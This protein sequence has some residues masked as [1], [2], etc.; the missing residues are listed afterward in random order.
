MNWRIWTPNRWTRDLSARR[1]KAPMTYSPSLETFRDARRPGQTWCRSGANCWPTRR[2]RCPPTSACAVLRRAPRPHLPAGKR[3]GRRDHRALLLPR[4]RPALRM[5]ASGPARGASGGPTARNEVTHDVDPLDVLR[6]CMARFQPVPGPR[7]APLLRRRGGLHR[8]R[9][10]RAVRAACRSARTGPRL[11]RPGASAHRHHRDLRPRAAHHE[12]GG[13]RPRRWRR[14]AAYDAAVLR[15]ST[16]AARSHVALPHPPARRARSPA[17]PAALQRDPRAVHRRRDKAKEYIRAGDIIQVVLSQRFEVEHTGDAARRL[18]RPAL[19]QS[20]AL[21]VLPGTRRPHAWSARPRR[22]TCAAKTARW[23]CAPSRAR[24]RARPTPPPTSPGRRAAGRPQ[25]A[26]RA[27]HA[28]RPGPQRHGPRLHLRHGAVPELMV[29]ER[30]SHVMHIVSDVRG[31]LAPGRDVYDLM[32]AT[33]PAGTVSG[34]PKI[35]AMEIIAELESPA[36]GPTRARS[37]TSAS[38][39]TSTVLHHHPHRAAQRAGRPMCRP[40]RASWP[41]PTPRASTRKR[42]TRPAACCRAGPGPALCLLA[43]PRAAGGVPMILVI[44]NYDSFTYNLVQYLGELGAEEGGAQRPDH[45]EARSRRCA[46]T[47][48]SS[49][50]ARARRRGG[51]LLRTHR[52]TRPRHAPCSA[53]ASATRPSA[54]CTAARSCARAG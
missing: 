30:Y 21:H 2:P 16:S 28:G 44:D 29:I 6:D 46:R 17:P 32:R 3:G 26:G 23:R 13:Q 31:R 5:R 48:S 42:R 7:P 54:R 18:P 14:D 52:R 1:T 41:T 22:C 10:G 15:A 51:H 34:A 19:R 45:G 25:G 9:R 50:P 39:A 49:A 38:T 37:A 47:S 8:L 36:A 27:H 40:A 24:A 43:R 4:R 12:G 35:R 33:F 11:A 53:S 20:L